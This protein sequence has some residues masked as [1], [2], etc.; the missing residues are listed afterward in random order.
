M[1]Q[2]RSPVSMEAGIRRRM[3][4]T[5]P[6]IR[7]STSPSWPPDYVGDKHHRALK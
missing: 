4:S 1:A 3:N 2:L 7:E 6:V 5:L